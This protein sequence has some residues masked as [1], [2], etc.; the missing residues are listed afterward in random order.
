MWESNLGRLHE[1]RTVNRSANMPP[2]KYLVIK[3]L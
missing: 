3:K 1:N 2:N